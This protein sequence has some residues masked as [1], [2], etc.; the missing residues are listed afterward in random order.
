MQKVYA[1][2][3]TTEKDII[4]EIAWVFT[5]KE[6]VHVCALVIIMYPFKK[7]NEFNST[8]SFD[9]TTNLVHWC[10]PWI[11]WL[12]HF[13]KVYCVTTFLTAFFNWD[14][15]KLFF[16]KRYMLIY[17][18]LMTCIHMATLARAEV[19]WMPVPLLPFWPWVSPK[20]WE[21]DVS[22]G[23]SHL[24]AWLAPAD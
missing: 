2:I 12:F 17:S 9:R 24:K 11:T 21:Q 16:L 10:L 22:Q 1:Y 20:D 6:S 8:K 15:V 18:G 19:L 3:F 4:A 7:I 5:P 13:I 14:A 23:C